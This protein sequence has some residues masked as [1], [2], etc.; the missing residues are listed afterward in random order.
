MIKSKNERV[1][2]RRGNIVYV[3]FG[4]SGNSSRQEGLRPVCIISNDKCNKSSPIVT[5]VPMTSKQKKMELP[6]HISIKKNDARGLRYDSVALVEQITSID[7][8]DI[9][10]VVV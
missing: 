8:K 2:L 1:K 6:T 5:V 9:K 10:W 7:K 3:D 4:K